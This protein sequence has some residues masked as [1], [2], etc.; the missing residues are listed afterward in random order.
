MSSIQVVGH[1]CVDLT[2]RFG[3]GHIAAPGELAEVGPMA[4]SIG[5]AVGNCGRTLAA[6]GVDVSLSAAVG[7]DELGATCLRLLRRRHGDA[8]DLAVTPDHATSYSVVVEPLGQDRSFW[9]HTGANDTFVG[10]CDVTARHLVHF[11]YPTLMPG[12]CADNGAPLVRLFGRAHAQGVA[13]S[14]DLAYLATN[15]PLRSLDWTTFFRA[16]LPVCDVFC[17]SWDDLTSSLGIPSGGG[18]A[19]VVAW[20]QTFLEWG[21]AVVLITLGSEGSYLATGTTERLGAL[22]ACG[23]DPRAWAR[24]EIWLAPEALADV[25][26]TNGAGDTFKAA[27]L[28]RLAQ[29]ADPQECL[30]FAHEVVGRHLRGQALTAS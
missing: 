22:G 23:I 1:V 4:I 27:F 18:R 25:V 17:P 24:R 7:D 28:A 8:V 26:T 10:E 13:T 14:L 6:L 11:G 29:G 9:H 20:A 3:S 15:S 30:E 19:A 2:P 5:G 12:I 16:V 21:A